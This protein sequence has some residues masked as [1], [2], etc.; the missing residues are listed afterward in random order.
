MRNE[1]Y[2]HL[3]DKTRM[4]ITELLKTCIKIKLW[5]VNFEY[6]PTIEEFYSVY[7]YIR[8]LNGVWE[9]IVTQERVDSM[10]D[11]TFFTDIYH[12]DGLDI[13]YDSSNKG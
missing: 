10:P 7:F 12:F 8:K 4:Y 11:I 9:L 13:I 6:G 1:P 2:Y 3:D 5:N